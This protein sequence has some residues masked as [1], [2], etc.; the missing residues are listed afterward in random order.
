MKKAEA[1]QQPTTPHSASLA[2]SVEIAVLLNSSFFILPFLDFVAFL[3]EL[4]EPAPPLHEEWA[5][6]QLEAHFSR[7]Q[8]V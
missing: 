7:A 4:A 8:V 1:G 2:L 5:G 3:N 6:L